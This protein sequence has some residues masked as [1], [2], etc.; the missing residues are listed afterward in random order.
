[1]PLTYKQE[2]MH[3][4]Y[5]AALMTPTFPGDLFMTLGISG[6]SVILRADG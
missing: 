2:N 3:I 1:M 5:G 4:K 6:D